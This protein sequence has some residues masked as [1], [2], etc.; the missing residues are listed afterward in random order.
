MVEQPDDA[1]DLSEL[2]LLVPGP[3]LESVALVG[4]G[5]FASAFDVDQAVFT[6]AAAANAAFGA[7]KHA[8]SACGP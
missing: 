4:D 1:V 5:S 3:A 7:G 6:A 2:E 8:R